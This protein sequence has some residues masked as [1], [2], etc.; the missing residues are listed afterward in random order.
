MRKNT[1]RFILVLFVLFLTVAITQANDE[2]LEKIR[3]AIRNTGAQWQADETSI[4]R[5]S[6]VERRAL[7]GGLLEKTPHSKVSEETSGIDLPSHF[8]W[9]DHNGYNWMTSIK[10][11][12]CDNCWAYAAVGAFEAMIKIES[13]QPTLSLDLSEAF[14][15]WCG[16]GACTPWYMSI[17]L[18]VLRDMGVPD[19]RCLLSFNCADTC[20]DRFFK[21]AFISSWGYTSSDVNLIKETIYNNGPVVVWMMIYTDFYYYSGGIYQY[22]HG[23]AEGGHFVVICG[24]DD[25]EGYWIC[26]NSWGTG[27][28]EAGWFRIRMG[29]NEAGIEQDVYQMNVDLPT[30][31]ER[32]KVKSPDNGEGCMAGYDAYIEWASA[33]YYGDIRIEYSTNEGQDWQLVVDNTTDDGRYHWDVPETPSSSCRVK[34]SDPVDGNPFDLSDDNFIIFL[35]GDANADTKIDIVDIVYVV[36]YALRSGPEPIPLKAGDAFCDEEVN[37]QDAVWLVNYVF[38]GGPEPQC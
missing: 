7:L 33:L 23:V 5:L 2:E 14:V 3:E 32:M 13:N 10:D 22:S 21:S 19:F 37:I 30:V 15:T 17:T 38:K 12:P 31:T 29:V 16:K 27:W 26:K 34:I 1:I 25:A 11:Q 6:P 8:D 28:G 24:W 4:S 18:D 9:R 20:E 35:I 36:N